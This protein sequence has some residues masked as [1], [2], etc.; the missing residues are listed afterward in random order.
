MEK[1]ISIIVP[2]YNVECYL[3]RCV[4]SIQNQT[5]KNLE[6]ILVDDGSPD[7][8]GEICDAYAKEDMRIRVLHKENGGLSDARNAGIQVANGEYIGFVDS[9]DY[10]NTHMYECLLQS[11]TNTS[12]D[13][14][15]C[16]LRYVKDADSC[17]VNQIQYTDEIREET[18]SG[19]EVQDKYFDKIER[20]TFTVAWNKLYK[21]ELFETIRYPKGKLHEDEFTT[22]KLL[23]Q[24]KRIAVINEI[25]YY[26]VIREGSIMGRFNAK[27]YD[28]LEAYRSKMNFYLEHKEERLFHQMIPLYMRMSAQYEKWMRGSISIEL[29]QRSVENRK[30]FLMLCKDNR[31]Q[32][33]L[34]GKEKMEYILYSINLKLYVFMW[35]ALR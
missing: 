18:L 19:R 21:R 23:Y 7:R 9:D 6:I 12:A 14:A 8:C 5:Y 1:L 15:I 33:G 10:I 3:K 31:K 11:I 29:K 34:S 27:R 20:V 2:I 17:D 22:Y 25:G 30:Q 16:G 28:L 4:E 13:V 35:N 24:A 32:L 26:Y